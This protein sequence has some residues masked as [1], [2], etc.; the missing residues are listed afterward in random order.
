[1]DKDFAYL[2]KHLLQ[3]DMRIRLPKAILTNL[4]AVAGVTSFE[5]YLDML[6][7]QI[8]LKKVEDS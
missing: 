4:Q 1:V 7:K 2:D 5:I 3:K 8:V 6:N